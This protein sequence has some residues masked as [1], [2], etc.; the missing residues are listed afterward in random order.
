MDSGVNCYSVRGPVQLRQ[1]LGKTIIDTQTYICI[2]NLI[3][4]ERDSA[5]K[6]RPS[7]FYV[8][9]EEK[10]AKFWASCLFF[11]PLISNSMVWDVNVY[12][13]DF[14]VSCFQPNNPIRQTL[15]LRPFH[16]VWLFFP[17]FLTASVIVF[18]GQ[19]PEK[20]FFLYLVL[21]LIVQVSDFRCQENES[22][23]HYWCNRFVIGSWIFNV[24]A[25]GGPPLDI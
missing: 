8:Y 19:S 11:C 1:K 9:F 6:I 15:A 14:G 23:I 21:Y 20:L 7:L 13:S 22:N 3:N 2:P 18:V 25:G 10:K 4:F 12:I 24:I 17:I 16:L 5:F